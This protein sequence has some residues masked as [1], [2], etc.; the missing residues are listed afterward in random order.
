[1]AAVGVG[2]TVVTG[3]GGR[4]AD[5]PPTSGPAARAGTHR[6]SDGLMAPDARHAAGASPTGTVFTDGRLTEQIHALVARSSEVTTLSTGTGPQRHVSGSAGSP[7]GSSGASGS[8]AATPR[9][10]GTAT[11]LPSCVVSGTGRPHD[12]PLA[13]AV[14]R[15]HGIPVGVVVYPASGNR[16]DVYIVDRA[17]GTSPSS[18]P[19]H[20]ELHRSVPRG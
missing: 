19:G 14:G 11:A 2:T 15:Y 12:A 7:S 4:G 20:V 8:S 5:R 3:V 9:A 17:C 16:L 6:P 1:M 13:T 10:G 18:T